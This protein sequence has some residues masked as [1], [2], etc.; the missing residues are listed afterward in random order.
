MEKCR[1]VISLAAREGAETEI[2][3]LKRDLKSIR[4]VGNEIAESQNLVEEGAGIRVVKNGSIGFSATN[5]FERAPLESAFRSALRIARSSAGNP[6]WSTLPKPEKYS[7]KPPV[8]N[9][10][11]KKLASK[12][13]EEIAELALEMLKQVT[14][15]VKGSS[16]L[17]CVLIILTEEFSILNS[18]GLEHLADP[19]TLIYSKIML[20]AKRDLGY[21]TAMKHFCS[22]HLAD[23]DPIGLVDEVTCDAT[24][25]LRLPKKRIGKTKSDVILSP[26]STGS[27]LTYLVAPMIVGRS[28]EQGATCFSNMLNKK[29]AADSF[30]LSDDG[31]VEGGLSSADVDDEGSSTRSTPIIKNGVLTGFLYDTLS[32]SSSGMVSTGNARRASDTLG[33]QYLTPPEPLPTNLVVGRGDYSPEE[34]IEETKEGILVSSFDYAFPLVPERGLFSMTSSLPVLLIEKGEEKGYTQNLTLSG[35]LGEFLT[36]ITGIGKNLGQSMFIGSIATLSPHVKVD[37]VS[38][39]YG[40]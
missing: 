28:V 30:S 8:P 14:K 10:Y 15:P 34:L 12:S 27:F 33:R 11:D 2:F 6:N 18:Q 4:I 36:R 24:Q 5:V 9:L 1:S 3:L 20:E 25:L 40:S 39:S 38:T 21:C 7:A 13:P 23:F 26:E 19:T 17:T 31:R 37:G 32:A 22:H 29:T 16:A 35:Q